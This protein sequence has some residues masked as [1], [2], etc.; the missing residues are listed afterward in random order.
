VAVISQDGPLALAR[1]QLENAVAALADPVPVW[2][3][4][5]C[6]WAPAVYSSLRRELSGGRRP[7]GRRGRLGSRSPCHIGMLDLIVDIDAPVGAWEPGAKGT[8]DRLHQLAGR[9]WRP[10]DCPVIDG[11][12]AQLQRWVVAAAEL[13]GPE[14]RVYLRQPCPSCGARHAYRRGGGAGEHVRAPALRVSEIGCRCG[15]CGASWDPDQFHWLA[16]LLGCPA[17]PA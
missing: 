15:A 1:R 7:I 5:V 4:G 8:V 9:G 13:L 10:Q 11:Y 3:G 17:L 2:D 14:P 16:R 12:T 6:R